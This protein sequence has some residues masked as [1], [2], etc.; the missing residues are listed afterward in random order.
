M[1]FIVAHGAFDVFGVIVLV[2][3]P[4]RRHRLRITF[5]YLSYNPMESSSFVELSCSCARYYLLNNIFL[6]PLFFFCFPWS[7]AE[8][9]MGV[10]N[11]N[12]FRSNMI[13]HAADHQYSYRRLHLGYQLINCQPCASALPVAS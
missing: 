11:V 12:I 10:R 8:R 4:S 9:P 5:P 6:R 7:G 1:E 2:M 3:M 13:G